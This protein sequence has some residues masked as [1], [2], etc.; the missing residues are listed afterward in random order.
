MTNPLERTNFMLTF[1]KGAAINEWAAQQGDLIHDWVEGNIA[2]GLYPTRLDTD[3]TIWTDTKQALL[4]A[5]REYHKGETAHRE[6]KKLRQEPG[7]VEDY[8][9][10]FQSLL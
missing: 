9:N 10:I 8:I 5:F 3:E 7:Q 2:Q 4:D 6:L 1:C